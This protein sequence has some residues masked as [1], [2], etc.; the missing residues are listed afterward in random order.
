M[1]LLAAALTPFVPNSLFKLLL[2]GRHVP[3]KNATKT[4][5]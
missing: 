3:D 2:H 4:L 1:P 5:Q